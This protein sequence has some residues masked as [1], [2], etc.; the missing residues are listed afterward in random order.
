MLTCVYY[1]LYKTTITIP[2]ITDSHK[3]ADG[4]IAVILIR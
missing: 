1:V 2:N 4:I 3:D